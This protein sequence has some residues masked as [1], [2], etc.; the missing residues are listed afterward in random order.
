MALEIALRPLGHVERD[1]PKIIL[2]EAKGTSLYDLATLL[3]YF[4]LPMAP[5]GADGPAI[6]VRFINKK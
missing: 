6:M 2:T 4:W 1:D 3:K 5:E